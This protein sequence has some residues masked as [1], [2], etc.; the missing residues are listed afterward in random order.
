VPGRGS[1]AD[2][3]A[4]LLERNPHDGAQQ[5]LVAI[6]VKLGLVE[7][8][9][10]K[11]PE[12]AKATIVAL[13]RDADEALETL[14]QR[15]RYMSTRTA[16][17]KSWNHYLKPLR[18]HPLHPEADVADQDRQPQSTKHAGWAAQPRRRPAGPR[19]TPCAH[20]SQPLASAK[21][22]PRRRDP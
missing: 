14:R 6:K 5:H 3:D 4:C 17:R 16:S 13:K 9:A 18:P 7:I 19:V 21:L 22:R 20:R 8:L 2:A 1:F 10:T 15:S 11:D 12:T